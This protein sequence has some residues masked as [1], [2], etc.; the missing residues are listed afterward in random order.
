MHEFSHNAR[1][2][3]ALS[4]PIML[5]SAGQNLIALT[6]SLFLYGYDENDFAA[7]GFISVFYLVLTGIGFGF[8]KGGQILIARKFGENAFDFVNK[9][10]YS[11]LFFEAV[12][13][14][15][16]FFALKFLG[17]QILG[18]FIK[19]DIILSKSLAFLDYRLYGLVFSFVGLSFLSLYM[20]IGR[21]KIIL[22]DTVFLG[23]I[24]LFLCYS[25]VYGRFGFPEM[26]IAGAGLASSLAE[27]AALLF[28]VVYMIFDRD[29]IPFRLKRVSSIAYAEIR[30]II[31][32]GVPIM[33]QSMIGIASWFVFFSFIEKLGE[34][35]LAISNLL[36]VLYLVFSVPCWGFASAINTIVSRSIGRGRERRVL[37]QVFHSSLI[38]MAVTAL[39]SFPFLIFGRVVL[40]PILGGEHGEVFYE[41]IPYF[42]L[43]YLI[44][45]IASFSIIY[46]NGVSGT[47]EGV[48]GLN[49]QIIGSLAYLLMAYFSISYPES[50]GLK[51]AWFSE[52][53]YWGVQCILSWWVLRSGQWYFIKF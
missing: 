1:R 13:G 46:F 23:V 9:Y 32:I 40:Q 21:P 35:A 34:R 16:L 45:L 53:L 18:I 6:D 15:L 37:K 38:S 29:L 28:F 3:F 48:K 10:F 26:G 25:F 17:P 47:G 39:I 14:L 8:S 49:I 24:N 52:V 7:V 27:G 36:R 51:W 42:S 11:I 33:L 19:S 22:I 4:V 5:G 41:A 31:K 30:Y 43:L 44:L 50:L 20:G 12:L 2:L